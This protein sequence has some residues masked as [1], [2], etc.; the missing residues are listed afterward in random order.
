M[1]RTAPR[2]RTVRTTDPSTNEVAAIE[3]AKSASVGQTLFVCARLLDEIALGR[4]RERTGIGLRRA[5]TALFPHLDLAGTRLTE[6]ARRVGVSKQAIAPLVDEM[7]E[8]G[9]LERVDDP[10]DARA[11]RIRFSSRGGQHGLLA[12][13]ATLGQLEAELATA[14]G[15]RRFVELKRSLDA[16][17]VALR[18]LETTAGD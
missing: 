7:V 3:R 4:V 8:M 1:A 5:H 2:P 10:Q 6:L 13:L 11:K 17:L 14:I 18:A 15:E 9:V 12:G 16:L